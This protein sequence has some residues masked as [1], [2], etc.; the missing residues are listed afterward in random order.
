MVTNPHA[1]TEKLLEVVF[2]VVHSTA[3]AKQ[4][5]SKHV[6][7]AMNQHSTIEEMLETVLSTQTIP[8]GYQWDKFRG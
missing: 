7:S 3:I 4:R 1:R 8:R 2:S 6:S 5:R